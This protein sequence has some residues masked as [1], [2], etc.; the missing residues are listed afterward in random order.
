MDSVLEQQ[1]EPVFICF[2]K[3][4]PTIKQQNAPPEWALDNLRVYPVY[5]KGA[6]FVPFGYFVTFN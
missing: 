5:S 3:P 1:L 4:A 2:W 6:F